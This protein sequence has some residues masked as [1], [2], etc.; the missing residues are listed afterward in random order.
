MKKLMSVEF[1]VSMD[2]LLPVM[3]PDEMKAKR[4]VEKAV[5]DFMYG[6][7][8]RAVNPYRTSVDPGPVEAVWRNFRILAPARV[9]EER[10]KK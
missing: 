6:G 4:F 9:L 7:H 1:T 3:P 10:R 2:V 8:L 5:L